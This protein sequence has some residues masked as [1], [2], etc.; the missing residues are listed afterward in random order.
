MFV[1]YFVW[2]CYM[3][4]QLFVF[5]VL[6]LHFFGEE[7]F[8]SIWI[9]LSWRKKLH[10]ESSLLLFFVICLC[11]FWGCCAY[12]SAS[13]FEL[14]AI[15]FPELENVVVNMNKNWFNSLVYLRF[16]LLWWFCLLMKIRKWIF[17]AVIHCDLALVGSICLNYQERG[18]FFIF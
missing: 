15:I 6:E 4:I 13:I 2:I 7:A 12:G 8:T 9:Y 17:F 1:V 18:L 3:I 5:V 10:N 16:D 11:F 14:F